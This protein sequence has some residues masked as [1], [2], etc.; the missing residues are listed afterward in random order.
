M[1][2]AFLDDLAETIWAGIGAFCI[3]F[4][5]VGL[6]M[7]ASTVIELWPHTSPLDVLK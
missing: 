2:K 1:M 3:A 4:V 5:L 7:A 6:Y